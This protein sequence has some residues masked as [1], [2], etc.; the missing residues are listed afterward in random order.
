VGRHP[1]AKRVLQ[2]I[3]RKAQVG[4]ELRGRLLVNQTAPVAV[5]ADLVSAGVN[6]AD[7]FGMPL[8]DSTEDEEGGADA[9]AVEQF[10]DAAGIV[11]HAAFPLIPPVAVNVLFKRRDLEIVLD[12]DRENVEYFSGGPH[13]GLTGA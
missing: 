10:E 11:G 7:Q 12:V 1:P 13:R 8:R 9:M 5:G 2:H 6:L 4:A 3:A